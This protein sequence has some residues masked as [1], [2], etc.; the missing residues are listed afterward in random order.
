MF[1]TIIIC[2]LLFAWWVHGQVLKSQ[3][4]DYLGR[5]FTDD[6][7]SDSGCPWED[8]EFPIDIGVHQTAIMDSDSILGDLKFKETDSNTFKYE[9]NLDVGYRVGEPHD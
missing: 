3:V 7:L 9:S 5:P 1:I 8:D 2:V 6:E 4:K